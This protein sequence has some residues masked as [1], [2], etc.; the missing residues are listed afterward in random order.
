MRKSFAF[1]LTAF[2]IAVVGTVVFAGTHD[3]AK[4][5][6]ASDE[7]LISNDMLVGTTLL[8]AGRYQ[9]ACDTKMVSFYLVNEGPNY[10][11]TKTKV[12][13]VPCDGNELQARRESTEMQMPPNKDGVRELKKLLIR[14]SNVEHLMPGQN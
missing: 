1:I 12:L 7:V 9:I 11:I 14:G 3:N 2:V 5:K 6:K 4:E 8:K 13:E 10:F